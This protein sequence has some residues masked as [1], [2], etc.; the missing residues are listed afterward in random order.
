M[1]ER[2]PAVPPLGGGLFTGLLRLV[3]LDD[4]SPKGVRRRVVVIA[5]LAWLPLL[6]LATV[7]GHLLEGVAVPFA[8][9]I[10]VHVRLLVVIPLLLVAEVEARRFLPTVVQEFPRRNL[11][12]ADAMPRFEAAVASGSRLRN[13][14]LAEAGLLVLVFAVFMGIIW[15]QYGSSY[16]STWYASSTPQGSQLTLAGHWLVFVS[17]PIVQFLMLR[18]YM[19][20]FT[21]ARFLWQVSRIRL[22][23]APTHPDRAGGLGFL[24]SSGHIFLMVAVAHGALAAGPIASLILFK[25]AALTE[26]ADELA[27]LIA[28]VICVVLGPLVFFMPQLVAAKKVGLFEYGRLAERYVRTFHDQVAGRPCTAPT[29][30]W[31]AAPTSSRWPTWAMP[32]AWSKGCASPRSLTSPSSGW[33]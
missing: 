13:S 5:L 26:F 22:E 14:A 30:R 15:R 20:I 7:Q 23:L 33:P 9:D 21:W 12:P 4:N 6:V 27:L 16:A 10:E 1:P 25:G 18:W 2:G 29:S 8:R 11:V 24:E 3:R 19:W 17:L 31:S 32:M 28:W